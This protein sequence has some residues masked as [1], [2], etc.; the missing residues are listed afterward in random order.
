MS[1]LRTQGLL[2]VSKRC[3]PLQLELQYDG[4]CCQLLVE[5]LDQFGG[6]IRLLRKKLDPPSNFHCFK[7]ISALEK[8]NNLRLRFYII[9][10]FTNAL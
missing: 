7:G 4:Q 3:Y 2:K 1:C 6:K 8:K 5:L 9:Q 10:E